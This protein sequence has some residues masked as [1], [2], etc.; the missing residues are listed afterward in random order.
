MKNYFYRLLTITLLSSLLLIPVLVKGDI[1]EIENPL[2]ADTFEELIM[3]IVDILFT[4]ALVIAPL[5]IIIAGFYFV[6]AAGNPDQINTAKKIILWAL[7]GLLI[8]LCA[9]GIIGLFYE[10]FELSP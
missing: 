1:I 10:V 2:Q 9:K 3:A 6:T 5:M 4:L 8:V 7:I